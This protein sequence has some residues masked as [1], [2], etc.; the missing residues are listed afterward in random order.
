MPADTAMGSSSDELD[1]IFEMDDEKREKIAGIRQAANYYGQP[2]AR[3]I[4]SLVLEGQPM[5][6]VQN[7]RT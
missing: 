1:T 7:K 6:S 4:S 2:K 5:M 3:Y